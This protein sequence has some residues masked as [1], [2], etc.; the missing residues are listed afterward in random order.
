MKF[1]NLKDEKQNYETAFTRYSDYSSTK[2]INSI[3]DD[4]ISDINEQ[5]IDDIFNK[6]V[7]NW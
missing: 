3:E 6:S 4:L 2:N 1:T 7:I 5:L